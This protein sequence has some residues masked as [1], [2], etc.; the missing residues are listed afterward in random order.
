MIVCI[1]GL[2][3][4]APPARLVRGVVRAGRELDYVTAARGAGA[5]RGRLLLRHALPQAFPVVLTQAAIVIPQYILAEVTLSFLG[6]GIADPAPSWGRLLGS[7]QKYHVL[8][9]YRWMAVPA[10]PLLATFLAYYSLS[11][12]PVPQSTSR[13]TA[14]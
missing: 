6:L 4:W 7:L 13:R 5:G 10:I 1:I 11:R 3:G 12:R 14:C 2:V 9:N 8:S